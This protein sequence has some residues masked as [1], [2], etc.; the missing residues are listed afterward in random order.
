[1]HHVKQNSEK[2][3][4]RLAG[5]VAL[6]SGGARGMG[7]AHVRRFAAEGAKV[8]FGDTLHDEGADL[9]AQIGDAVR[10]VPMDVSVAT[11]W[12]RAIEAAEADFGPVNVL[13]NNAGIVLRGSIE[14]FSEADYRK[15]IDVNQTSVFLGMKAVLP[16]MRRAGGGSI[17][18]ISSVAGIVGRPETVAY[19]ASKFAI[20]GMTKV[21]A[22]EF[23]EFNIRVNSV[24]PGAILTPMFAG[25]DDRVKNSLTADLALKRLA[26]PEEVTNLVLFLASDESAYCTASEFIIDG[27]LI[28]R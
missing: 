18:N 28:G 25:M 10:F 23:G 4:A 9:A 19:T 17:I 12:A 26:Q 22:A 11:E 24:H 21:A 2:A 6:V 15:V 13:V 8:L 16:S 14:S 7:A 5:K 20:R 1:V 3:V 27:G